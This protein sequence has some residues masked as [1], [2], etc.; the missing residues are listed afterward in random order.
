MIG[1]NTKKIPEYVYFVDADD[2]IIRG[3]FIHPQKGFRNRKFK[4]KEEIKNNNGIKSE[5]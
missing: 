2:G 5:N 4:I 3:P 1:K